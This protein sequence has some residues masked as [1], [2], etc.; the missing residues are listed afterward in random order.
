MLILIT[1]LL[2]YLVVQETRGHQVFR[3]SCKSTRGP[4]TGSETSKAKS[5]HPKLAK[6]GSKVSP[7]A[8]QEQIKDDIKEEWR[9]DVAV[10]LPPNKKFANR[11][12]VLDPVPEHLLQQSFPSSKGQVEKGRPRRISIDV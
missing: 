6:C 4:G 7:T 11:D 3:S 5:N 9:D 10:S 8:S 1:G 12:M 2:C